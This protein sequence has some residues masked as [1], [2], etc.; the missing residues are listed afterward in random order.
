MAAQFSPSKDQKVMEIKEGEGNQRGANTGIKKSSPFT[1][2][3]EANEI[4]DPLALFEHLT[5]DQDKVDWQN[6]TP[7]FQLYCLDLFLAKEFDI[8]LFGLETLK[9]I[10]EQ[11][12]TMEAYKTLSGITCGPLKTKCF[13]E[14]L[15]LRTK[16]LP[17]DKEKSRILVDIFCYENLPPL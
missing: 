6:M 15:R 9:K 1:M 13:Y 17:D 2:P 16:P 4:V 10:A 5:T 3:K 8:R 11:I 7:E 14:I 12:E